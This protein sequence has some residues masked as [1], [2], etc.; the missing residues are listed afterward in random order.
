MN[1]FWGQN[2][3]RVPAQTE[4]GKHQVG[5]DFELFPYIHFNKIWLLA[6]PPPPQKKKVCSPVG[7]WYLL[8]VR[9]E[10]RCCFSWHCHSVCLCHYEMNL[11]HIFSKFFLVTFHFIIKISKY[12]A[13]VKKEK[14]LSAFQCKV[15]RATWKIKIWC[16]CV[17]GGGD[18]MEKW[19]V[20]DNI[21]TKSPLQIIYYL[22]T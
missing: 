17:C 16:V 13:H 22:F 7:E 21:K 20:T 11:Q 2:F 6:L 10:V 1:Q 12:G 15:A 18:H 14:I 3:L 5:E 8:P 4:C 19:M 9:R